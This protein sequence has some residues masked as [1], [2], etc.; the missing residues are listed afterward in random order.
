[1][2]RTI[3]ATTVVMLT[4]ASG[5]S[6]STEQGHGDN[7]RQ[8]TVTA[9]RTETKSPPP[10]EPQRT[11]LPPENPEPSGPAEAC[12]YTDSRPAVELGSNGSAVR[13]AQCYLNLTSADGQIPEDGDFGPVTEEATER[14]QSCAG[15]TVDGLIGPETWAYLTH[16]AGSPT[17]LC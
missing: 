6:I 1:M 10:P 4:A 12:V 13:Q 15:I 11:G 7:T 16:W 17:Y 8:P 14:F 2:R 3:F 5:C 9:T